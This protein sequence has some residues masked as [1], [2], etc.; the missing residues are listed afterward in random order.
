MDAFSVAA[1]KKEKLQEKVS[2]VLFIDLWCLV[3][4]KYFIS[5]WI[6]I[7]HAVKDLNRKVT[8]SSQLEMSFESSGVALGEPCLLNAHENHLRNGSDIESH[9]FDEKPACLKCN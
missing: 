2:E 8:I 3:M 9:Y 1:K 5:L 7:Q 6:N 4:I